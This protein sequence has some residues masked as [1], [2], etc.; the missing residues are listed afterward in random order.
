MA[1]DPA[2]VRVE[3]MLATLSTLSIRIAPWFKRRAI[4]LANRGFP[5]TGTEHDAYYGLPTVKAH[6]N[7]LVR[8]KGSFVTPYR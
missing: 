8:E 4:I 7:A 1:I 6:R 3:R 2:K 5:G